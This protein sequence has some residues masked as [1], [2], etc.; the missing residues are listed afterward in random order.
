MLNSLFPILEGSELYL[1]YN[2]NQRLGCRMC[3]SA[4]LAGRYWVG[5][6]FPM[7]FHALSMALPCFIHGLSMLY[8]CLY[9]AFT[10][11]IPCLIHR[12]GIGGGWRKRGCGIGLLKGCY[13]GAREQVQG[14]GSSYRVYLGVGA[15]EGEK[16]AARVVVR[17]GSCRE[18][19]GKLFHWSEGYAAVVCLIEGR[20]GRGIAFY[21]I[22]RVRTSNLM[23]CFTTVQRFISIIW[24]NSM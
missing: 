13:R 8:P 3:D 20:A 7:A 21:T 12:Y 18:G 22:L 15:W 4:L 16:E 10:M 24:W 11:D 9:H 14:K 17:G 6:D 1:T 2:A 23:R 19:E 5:T